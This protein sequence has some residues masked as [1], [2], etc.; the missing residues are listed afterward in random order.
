MSLHIGH[1]WGRHVK[2]NIMGQSNII[3]SLHI[4]HTWG[5]HVKSNIM[6]QSNIIVVVVVIVLDFFHF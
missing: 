6:G 1:T 3:M 2:S 5:R 4:G